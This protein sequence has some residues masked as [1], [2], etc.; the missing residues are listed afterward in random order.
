M[1]WSHPLKSLR[2]LTCQI[3]LLS[4]VPIFSSLGSLFSPYMNVRLFLYLIFLSCTLWIA[5][6]TEKTSS[7]SLAILHYLPSVLSSLQSDWG[8]LR[9]LQFSFTKVNSNLLIAKDPGHVSALNLT[10]TWHLTM[11]VTL[12]FKFSSLVWLFLLGFALLVI[13]NLLFWSI[14]SFLEKNY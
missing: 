7:K 11:P 13:S 14:L 2:T 8:H 12:F 10:L 6:F 4:L 9:P 1:Y 5:C 3:L